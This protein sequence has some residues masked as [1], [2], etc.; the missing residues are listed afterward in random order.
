MK[1]A[2]KIF[3]ELPDGSEFVGGGESSARLTG[4]VATEID[5]DIIDDGDV[6]GIKA[7]ERFGET[8]FTFSLS[9]RAGNGMIILTKTEMLE[10]IKE[11]ER[12]IYDRHTT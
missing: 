10:L 1:D 7:F 3:D 6:I 12:R 9:H 8:Y 2:S 5:L 11:A 4:S